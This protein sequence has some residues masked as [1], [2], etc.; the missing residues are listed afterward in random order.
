M[1]SVPMTLISL[2][3]TLIIILVEIARALSYLRKTLM[4][5]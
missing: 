1:F 3:N 5:P 4:R 2:K